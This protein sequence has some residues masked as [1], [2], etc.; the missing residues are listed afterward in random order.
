MT[1]AQQQPFSGRAPFPAGQ[2]GILPRG[3]LSVETLLVLLV[4]L[5][6]LGIAYLATSK[7]GVGAERRIESALARNSFNDLVSAIDQACSLGSG[8]V[9]VVEVKGGPAEISSSGQEFFFKA[10]EFSAGANSSCEVTTAATSPAKTFTIRN[11]GG[12]IEIS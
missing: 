10:K 2:C 6:L 3:Q 9:R 7:I 1:T 11:T 5:V 4:F 8:N 12:A